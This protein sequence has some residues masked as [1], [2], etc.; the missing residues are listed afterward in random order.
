MLKRQAGSSA[1]DLKATNTAWANFKR[2]QN[3]GSKLGADSGNFSPSQLQNAVR[4]LDKS[5][6]KAAFARG[7]A[8]M[9]DLG[10]AGKSVLGN[11]VPDSGTAGRLIMGGGALGSYLINPA[12]PASLLG[13]AGLYT[14]PAQSFLNALITKRPELAQSIASSVKQSSPYLTPAALGLLNYQ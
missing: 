12:I 10:D 11:K 6:D 2:V 13:G 8:L 4:A 14:Q 3:A 1:D 7:N 5:K 9:Q